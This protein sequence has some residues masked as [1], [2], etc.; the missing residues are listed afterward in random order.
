M[1]TPEKKPPRYRSK[2]GRYLDIVQFPEGTEEFPP[3]VTIPQSGGQPIRF[4]AV[5]ELDMSEVGLDERIGRIHAAA[6]KSDEE[7]FDSEVKVLLFD[8]ARYAAED[9]IAP[10]RVRA[11]AKRIVEGIEKASISLD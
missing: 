2:D 4:D 6:D 10:V 9:G 5:P 1:S 7:V 11:A 8:L 3:Y